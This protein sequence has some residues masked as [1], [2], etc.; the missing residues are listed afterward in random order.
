LELLRFGDVADLSAVVLQDTVGQSE[1]DV[2]CAGT[3]CEAKLAVVE[4][5]DVLQVKG[6]VRGWGAG[7][8]GVALLN[9]KRGS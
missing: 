9:G 1:A 7:V 3:E 8:S 2:E 6:A 4:C 5:S